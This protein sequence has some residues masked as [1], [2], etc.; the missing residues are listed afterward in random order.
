MPLQWS[1][2]I[3]LHQDHGACV[4]EYGV[5]CPGLLILGCSL[6]PRCDSGATLTSLGSHPLSADRWASSTF[7]PR[8]GQQR[9]TYWGSSGPW[10]T[11]I[12]EHLAMTADYVMPH[13]RSHADC[14]LAPCSREL[15]YIDSGP[16]VST[17][18]GVTLLLITWQSSSPCDD[19]C[20]PSFTLPFLG[21]HYYCY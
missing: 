21:P 7:I 5:H 17:G 16:A 9:C 4:T 10:V 3:P 13:I 2:P 19:V 14:G 11:I 20:H 6:R 18:P 8:S 12:S 15:K 1:S